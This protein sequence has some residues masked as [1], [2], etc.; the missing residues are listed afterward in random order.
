MT[1]MTLR[2][3]LA[4]LLLALTGP[5]STSEI[6]QGERPGATSHRHWVLQS[7]VGNGFAQIVQL[8]ENRPERF[9]T[10]LAVVTPAR[11]HAIVREDLT[12]AAGVLTYSFRFSDEESG[13]WVAVTETAEIGIASLEDLDPD[14]LA[15]AS[16]RG[17]VTGT[18]ETARGRQVLRQQDLA[19]HELDRPEDR[20]L[21]EL[22]RGSDMPAAVGE[23]V[24]FLAVACE[25]VAKEIGAGA[26][27][28]LA[29]LARVTAPGVAAPPAS[30]WQVSVAPI[31]T[32]APAEG[33]PAGILLGEFA[34][35]AAA[36]PG[37]GWEG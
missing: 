2:F 33:S 35:L 36:K 25:L 27:R 15:A 18:V 28:H 19:P 17:R 31:Q 30:S 34:S 9:S 13:W 22:L 7:A 8:V 16:A 32:G 26:C 23:Q 1:P 10:T 29:A 3:A 4:V 24:Q 20:P 14:H 6:D 11:H 5:A 21:R 12:V 37:T